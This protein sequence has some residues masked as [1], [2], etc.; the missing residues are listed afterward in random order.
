MMIGP[1]NE[2]AIYRSLLTS[3]LI[4]LISLCMS[5][6]MRR[7][8]ECAS[9]QMENEMLTAEMCFISDACEWSHRP[10]RSAARA[11]RYVQ[12]KSILHRGAVLTCWVQTKASAIRTT[13]TTGPRI[14]LVLVA[15]YIYLYQ[16]ISPGQIWTDKVLARFILWGSLVVISSSYAV[17]DVM[18]VWSNERQSVCFQ[19]KVPTKVCLFSPYHFFLLV[20]SVITVSVWACSSLWISLLCR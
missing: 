12:L 5:E 4:A 1:V 6:C 11:D 20:L 19:P 3:H 9:E 8:F 10:S 18:A 17:W 15:C 2:W 14:R 13:R 7:G 16:L